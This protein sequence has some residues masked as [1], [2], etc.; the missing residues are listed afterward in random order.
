MP[1]PRSGTELESLEAQRDALERKIKQVA[2]REKAKKAAEDHR[3]WLLAGQI[4]VQQM[5]AAPD[6]DLFKL[7]MGLLDGLRSASDRKLFGLSSKASNGS[8]NDDSGPSL[9]PNANVVA[10]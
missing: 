1:R 6:S 5:Q 3:R 9:L 4:A 8:G 7:M 10:E 2:A